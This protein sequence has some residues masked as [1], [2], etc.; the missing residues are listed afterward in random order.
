[1]NLHWTS[2]EI[3]KIRSSWADVMAL[4]Y[5]RDND[6]INKIF[7]QLVLENAAARALLADPK[8]F[9]E[10]KELFAEILKFS[11]LY[12]H[13]RAVLEECMSE[14][15]T[16]NPSLVVYGVTY[17]EPLGAVMIK[18]LRGVLG[19]ERFKYDLE[20]LWVKL[21]IFIAN[22]ILLNDA[23][24]SESDG[25][26][27]LVDSMTAP[28]RLQSG[29][30]A[31]S[32]PATSY[33]ASPLPTSPLAPD[34]GL[35]R[36]NIDLG[37]NEKYKGF[38]RNSQGL[39]TLSLVVPPVIA[40]KPIVEVDAEPT[41]TPRSNR[42]NTSHMLE[43]LGLLSENLSSPVA[44]EKSQ[45]T[46]APFDPR[47]K[48]F[49]RRTPS[50][51]HVAL[52]PPQSRH[53]YSSSEGSINDRYLEE[54][55]V[56]SLPEEPKSNVFDS[57]S[58]GI[59]ALAPIA[60]SEPDCLEDTISTT[61]SR[62]GPDDL[63][64]EASSGTSSLSLHNL[65]YKSSISSGSGNSGVDTSF[66]TGGA[67]LASPQP[68]SLGFPY[69]SKEYDSPYS[70]RSYLSL[71]P[72]LGISEG[73]RASVGF[74]KSSYILKKDMSREERDVSDVVSMCRSLSYTKPRSYARSVFSLPPDRS[75]AEE[76][77]Y[78]FVPP[79]RLPCA[80]EEAPAKSPKVELIPKH[81]PIAT[82]VAARSMAPLIMSGASSKSSTKKG[83]FKKLHSMFGSEKKT[84]SAPMPMQSAKPAP[85]ISSAAFSSAAFS[86]R[87]SS[88]EVRS[89]HATLG[90]SELFSLNDGAVSA[91]E[92]KKTLRSLFKKAPV[93]VGSEKEKRNKYYVKKVPYKTIYMKDLIHS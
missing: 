9:A 65:D 44:P 86:S 79:P 68:R 45:P 30:S 93:A 62:Y 24:S 42:R 75:P 61:S 84:I 15:I 83:F 36:L 14:F 33:A 85:S 72:H 21:Y 3:V 6:F 37:A 48:S 64:L 67:L 53:S 52:S 78:N 71:V 73:R 5:Y 22:S 92:S 32:T 18:A 81:Q 31:P 4:N 90:R 76:T 40:S 58:F 29:N 74:M 47:R 77:T 11:M 39:E 25:E 59:G 87:L 23:N 54:E 28:L 10:Q 63:A 55:I 19:E 34:F 70:K 26:G 50:E 57:K 41:L 56:F 88:S 16:E 38:R 12:M 13:K 91:V 51:T 80:S 46:M 60:E 69:L 49:H 8:V 89:S 2:T 27:S 20:G 1:M 35:A 43:K 7:E 17:L 66:K 82:P